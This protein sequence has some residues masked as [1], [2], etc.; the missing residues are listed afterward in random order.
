[1]PPSSHRRFTVVQLVKVTLIIWYDIA[2]DIQS[3]DI[4]ETK[5]E[6]G[7][8][9]D[10]QAVDIAET[11]VEYG[12]KDDTQAVDIEEA[13]VEYGAEDVTTDC[14]LSIASAEFDSAEENNAIRRTKYDKKRTS[15]ITAF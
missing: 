3:F 9:D 14:V 10:T 15:A 7:A 8:E 5:G 2:G 6:Y 4:E 1:M 11:K 12:A 13:K